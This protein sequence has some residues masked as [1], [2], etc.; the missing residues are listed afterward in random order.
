MHK[1]LCSSCL[2]RSITVVSSLPTRRLSCSPVCLNSQWFALYENVH[3]VFSELPP[4][5]SSSFY[6]SQIGLIYPN[7][8]RL[9]RPFM[10]SVPTVADGSE[11]GGSDIVDDEVNGSLLGILTGNQSLYDEDIFFAQV[12]ESN[13]EL[14]VVPPRD[15]LPA[16]TP[17][18][19]CFKKNVKT[20][21]DRERVV[22]SSRKQ[23]V[24][25]R[26]NSMFSLAN[27]STVASSL[28]DANTECP[29][30]PDQNESE[31]PASNLK[32]GGEM[33]LPE[34]MDIIDKSDMVALRSQLDAS[35]WPK[36]VLSPYEVSRIFTLVIDK[37]RD[38]E[39]CREIMRD[40]ACASSRHFLP[41]HIPLL[42]A[43]RSAREEGVQRAIEALQFH[44]KAFIM[45]PVS[46]RGHES[47]RAAATR[48][49]WREVA[50]MSEHAHSTEVYECGVR[51]GLLDG[52]RELVEETL[53]E[54]MSRDASFSSLF[55][56]WVMMGERY[57]NRHHGMGV[58]VRAAMHQKDS[59]RM[60]SLVSL[61]SFVASC[62]SLRMETFIVHLVLNL[63]SMGEENAAKH[64]FSLV[65]IHGKYWKEILI[66]IERDQTSEDL[67][68]VEK[69]A[70][71]ITY[72]VIGKLRKSEKNKEAEGG[73][74]EEA[75]KVEEEEGEKDHL[76]AMME[77]I[78]WKSKGGKNDRR[79][80]GQNKVKKRVKVDQ[81][82][83]HELVDRIQKVWLHLETKLNGSSSEGM[84]RL[85]NWSS[86]HRLPVPP[87]ISQMISDEKKIKRESGV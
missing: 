87:S 77:M 38:C 54:K 35:F 15:L 82:E 80:K 40:F 81:K 39:E 68:L 32:R 63:L 44:N 67:I 61:S 56:E 29:V 24:R 14:D 42:M 20:T 57:G 30:E 5:S 83:V 10:S 34:L 71:L 41:S 11:L 79:R 16:S 60:N 37:A 45:A 51:M 85:V 70:N 1:F 55:R 73:I 13:L 53:K 9:R 33:D 8:S 12:E 27:A 49:L 4:S 43:V 48:S 46:L 66:E 65:S 2:Q 58:V 19:S 7:S 23:G 18:G 76:S 6:E 59:M 52:T 21:Q 28:I 31:T 64:V 75:E 47:L 69:I 74:V 3:P 36:A 25:S 86:L 72:G 22:R 62:S 84:A 50:K 78:V 17:L 26:L